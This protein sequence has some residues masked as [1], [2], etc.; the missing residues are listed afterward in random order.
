MAT[1]TSGTAPFVLLSGYFSES[2][3]TAGQSD[4][5]TLSVKVQSNTCFSDSPNLQFEGTA[6][7]T[8]LG[9]SSFPVNDQVLSVSATKDSTATHLSGSYRV[10]GGCADGET[11]TINGTKYSGLTG[12]YAGPVTGVAGGGNIQIAVTQDPKGTA[13]GLFFVTGKATF[14]GFPCF[15]AGTL[16]VPYGEVSGSSESLAFQT[17]E[18]GGSQVILNGTFNAAASALSLTS[19]NVLGGNCSGSFGAAQLTLQ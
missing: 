17:N 2:A 8:G 6:D 18:T 10:T 5:L 4:Y 14:Q 3:H 13:D 11:G 16:S 7:E 12:L 15:T 19:I 9:I 1:P